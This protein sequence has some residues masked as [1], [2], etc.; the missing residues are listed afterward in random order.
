MS[1]M[2]KFAFP[3]DRE[4]SFIESIRVIDGTPRFLEEHLMRIQQSLAAADGGDGTAAGAASTTAEDILNRALEQTL[5]SSCSQARVA[6]AGA[7]AAGDGATGD[8]AATA[9][10][11]DAGDDSSLGTAGAAGRTEFAGVWKLRFVYSPGGLQEC[12]LTPY[13]PRPITHLR[14]QPL[15]TDRPR[16]K[17]YPYKFL[18]RHLLRSPAG[19]PETEEPLF[20][21]NGCVTDAGFASAA[22][23]SGQQWYTPDTP[24]LPG[25]TRMRLLREGVLTEARITVAELEKFSAVCLFNAMLPLGSLQLPITAV[26]KP[27]EL[28]QYT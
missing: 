26:Q 23:R 21:Y 11:G 3:L 25:T 9:S 7:G 18:D 20:L 15:P 1:C 5:E 13:T 28:E 17:I 4:T 12:S 10:A 8:G 6:V 24:L 19:S 16:T 27:Y 2:R 14:L 22:F